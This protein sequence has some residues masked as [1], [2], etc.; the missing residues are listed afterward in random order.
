MGRTAVI[1]AGLAGLTAARRL[2]EAGREVVVFEKARGPGG[3]CATRRTD[4]DA[5]DHGAQYFTVR[6][7]AFERT[8]DGWRE[9]GVVARW[10]G[11]FQVLRDGE[12]RPAPGS[13]TRWVG[14]P[15]MSAIGRHLS[16]GLP[17]EA[18]TRIAS[19][20]RDERGW[21]LSA[22][23]GAS[24]EAFDAVVVAT[25]AAQAV[26]LLA[27]RPELA[28]VAETA[29]LAPCQAVMVRFEE[30]PDL[31]FGGAFVEDS[32]LSWVARQS[33]K[34]GRDE[35]PA[36]VLHA[37]AE[38]SAQHVEASPR[39]IVDALV[40]AFAGALGAPLPPVAWSTAHRW[41][42]ALPSKHLEA[43]HLWDAGAEVGACG[44]WLCGARLESA[45]A[46]GESLA[47]AMLA[48]A[49]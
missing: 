41:L 16:A 28:R 9:A 18:S 20:E 36:F 26:P 14:Q 44:D 22:E 42:Y 38:W 12:A 5:F 11:P 19:V 49:G 23:N 45:V 17:I 15:R 47:A 6:S 37:S 39:A 10:D 27:A 7:P 3:R 43:G 8:V 4:D 40:A 46:S 31:A 30:A 21:R 25:P 24:Y 33:S 13:T 1:G 32:P 34:P 48:D 2:Q 35:A 29:E